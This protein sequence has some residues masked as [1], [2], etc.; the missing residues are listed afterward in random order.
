MDPHDRADRSRT[1]TRPSLPR[2]E[3]PRAHVLIVDDE[4]A[5]RDVLRTVLRARFD[6]SVAEHGGE[7]MRVI[8]ANET[9]IDLVLSDVRMP[10]VHGVE[11]H[12]GLVARRHPL[13]Q[14]FVWMTGGGLSEGLRRYVSATGLPVIDKPFRLDELE[15]MLARL[16]APDAA[17]PGANAG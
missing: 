2:V 15:S 8:E 1:R 3:A 13:A 10:W 7:A 14:R 5:L 9:D 17:P 4:A 11:L 16:T 12:R 6:V